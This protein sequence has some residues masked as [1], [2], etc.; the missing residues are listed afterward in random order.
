MEERDLDLIKKYSPKDEV[1][2]NLY[3]E[4]LDFEKEL[5]KLE[6]KPYLTPEEEMSLRELKKKKLAGR[7][8]MENILRKYRAVEKSSKE[9]D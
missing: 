2:S 9:R 1:L 3:E 4:H 5:E 8:K 6:N 7:D